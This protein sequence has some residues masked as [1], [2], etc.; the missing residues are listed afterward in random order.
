MSN[1]TSIKNSK[2]LDKNK[3]YSH[4][5]NKGVENRNLF[6]DQQDY[7]V[8][9]GFLKDYLTPPPDSEKV[10]K[11][12]SVKGR[13]FKGIPHQPK[14]YF[15]KV[16]LIAYC[17]MPDHFHLLVNQLIEGSLE[18]FIRSLCT[19][20]AIYYNKRHQRRGS[21]FSGPY[22]KVD[23]TNVSELLHL[24]R[25]FHR[26]PFQENLN[27][28]NLS[29]NVYTSYRDYLGARVTPWIKSNSALS[30]FDKSKNKYFKGVS[31]Y[32]NFVEKYKLK[33]EEK[34]TLERIIIESVPEKL[35]RRNLKVEKTKSFKEVPTEP[36]S[37]PRSKIP[38]FTA[39]T[40][41]VFVLLITLGVRNIKISEA[42]TK[43]SMTAG[44]SGPIHLLAK[45]KSLLETDIS[46]IMPAL[47]P[48][49]PLSEPV[50]GQ[51]SGMEDE[52]PE[53]VKIL[54]IKINDE[55]ESVNVRKGPTTKSEKIGKA[56]DGDTFELVSQDSGWYQIKLDDGEIAFVSAR[57]A[58]IEEGEI[59]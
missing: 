57:Y 46:S 40:T 36:V 11:T 22:K 12:F 38:E 13:T 31:G 35:E 16:E 33:R 32:K 52:K 21:L 24:T 56:K 14:N 34:K 41:V 29:K 26:E 3:V 55:S 17:L 44:L 51:V 48:T 50:S 43:N 18:K 8:F 19:R 49:P 9:L 6:N 39:T 28:N 47:S 53:A 59:N 5:Y 1:N 20:Y 23:I 10:K 27:D 4:I 37:K 25:Y 54:V 30:Y 2:K 58:E 7:E 42:Q 15:K 45:V